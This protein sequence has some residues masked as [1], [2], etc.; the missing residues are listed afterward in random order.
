[1]KYDI[2]KDQTMPT[3]L[4]NKL[5]EVFE[6]RAN[7]LGYKGKKKKELQTEFLLGAVATIDTIMGNE[8]SSVPAGWWVDI[9]RGDLIQTREEVSK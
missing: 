2:Q 4:Q 8:K 6:G 9:M 1:M 3:E 7:A 5:V